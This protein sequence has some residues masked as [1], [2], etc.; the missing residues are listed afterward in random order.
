MNDKPI[1]EEGEYSAVALSVPFSELNN[2]PSIS[3]YNE[4]HFKSS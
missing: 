4:M 3:I 1:K 2:F